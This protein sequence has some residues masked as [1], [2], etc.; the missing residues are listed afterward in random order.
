MHYQWS[1]IVF[2]IGFGAY[3]AIR[4]RFIERAK[5]I[6]RIH[7]Q[8]DWIEFVLFAVVFAGNLLLPLTYLFTPLLRFADYQL[9]A[10][11][12]WCGAPLLA[13]ALWLFW[14]SHVD[15][16]DNWSVSLEIRNGHELITH[17]VY[18]RVRHPMYAA[19]LL[20]GLA[21]A[22]LLPNWLAGWSALVSFAILCVVR[23]PREERMMRARF[24]P[25]YQ[26]YALRTGRIIPRR[27]LR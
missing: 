6:E 26:E 20:F 19:I 5:S 17:G 13:I 16:G 21:Q 18:R 2:A 22:L 15:L 25:A 10:A 9:P 7:R 14:R 23:L 12:P 27:M 1:E 8:V 4:H 24:G 3:I 11:A